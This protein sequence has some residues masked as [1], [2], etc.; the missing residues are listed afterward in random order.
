[1]H[2][3]DFQAREEELYELPQF[4]R[5]AHWPWRGSWAQFSSDHRYLC[6]FQKRE[7][8]VYELDRTP[9]QVPPEGQRLFTELWTGTRLQRG[10]A[11]ELTP[12]EYQRRR[13]QWA[14][15]AGSDW[16]LNPVWV[17]R[18]EDWPWWWSLPGVVVLLVGLFFITR[19]SKEP[20]R[21]AGES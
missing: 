3:V 18:A 19:A 10:L 2:R 14:E 1:M 11:V 17:N 16:G 12:A 7:T 21:R 4:K 20:S 5:V 13:E 8:L 6:V 9:P 15:E